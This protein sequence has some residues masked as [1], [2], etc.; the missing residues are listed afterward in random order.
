MR[1]GVLA[2]QVGTTLE[3]V[4]YYET[5]GLVSQPERTGSGYRDFSEGDAERLRFILKAKRL[6]FRLDE[7]K[8]ILM[9]HG[10]GQ[11]VCEHVLA[12]LDDCTILCAQ[13]HRCMVVPVW[14]VCSLYVRARTPLFVCVRSYE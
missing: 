6:G 9:Q 10:H 7:I 3:T 12:L 11:I 4:R 1:I 8:G 14:C 5:I 2:K 13:V